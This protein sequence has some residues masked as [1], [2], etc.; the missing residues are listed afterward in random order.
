M[1][2]FHPLTH[3]K[4]KHARKSRKIRQLSFSSQVSM[5]FSGSLL[6]SN[7]DKREKKT[8]SAHTCVAMVQGTSELNHRKIS[9]TQT[10]GVSFFFQNDKSALVVTNND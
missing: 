2:T 7:S 4:W 6:C 10:T 8:L 1:E 9:I 5:E 3:T